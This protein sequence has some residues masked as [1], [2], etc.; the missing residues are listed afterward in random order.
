M[1]SR[2]E[3]VV[4]ARLR[5]GSLVSGESIA[6]E[7]KVSR[8]YIHKVVDKMR[9]W[10]IPIVSTPGSGY[11][12]PLT[13]DLLKV[14]ELLAI[15]GTEASITYFEKCARSSQD[16]ARELAN[17]GASSW[18]TVI[19]GEMTSGR[20]RLGR[21]WYASSGGLWFTVII[22]PDFTGSL[23][24]LSLASGVSVAEAISALLELDARVKWPNDVLVSEKKVCGI[25]VEGEAEA[26]RIKFLLIGIGVNVNNDI[27]VEL[28]ETAASLRSLIGRNVPRATLLASILSRLMTYY[29]YLSSGRPDVVVN[30]WK[31]LSATI[32]RVVRV[33]TVDGE[34]I[35]GRA[36]SVDRLGRLVVEVSGARRHIEAGDVYHLRF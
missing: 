15:V 3:K 36:I 16:I 11:R 34:E 9:K 4:L 35:V 1:L 26:D 10:G 31:K 25:L 7:L 29:R 24:L 17:S 13:D 20:G 12:I 27:P 21:T 14:S 6:S 30:T 5:S 32:G 2:S 22:K 33:V 19:C 18:S 8:S 23:Q 28:R